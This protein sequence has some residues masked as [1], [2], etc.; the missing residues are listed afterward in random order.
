MRLTMRYVERRGP[1]RLPS[2]GPVA[3]VAELG[4][5]GRQPPSVPGR[6]SLQFLVCFDVIAQLKPALGGFDGPPRCG[7][8]QHYHRVTPFRFPAR[9]SSE[10]ETIVLP[11]SRIC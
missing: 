11:N 4:A 9:S 1:S 8:V 3:A 6:D 10:R 5:V 2:P 7:F